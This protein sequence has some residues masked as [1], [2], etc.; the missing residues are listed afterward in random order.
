[1]MMAQ[2]SG[3]VSCT[4]S[5]SSS[6]DEWEEEAVGVDVYHFFESLGDGSWRLG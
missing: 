2:W 1:M 3:G 6:V 5:S 4:S